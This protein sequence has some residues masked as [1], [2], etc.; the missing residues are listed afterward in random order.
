MTRE[1]SNIIM[2]MSILASSLF[3]IVLGHS[4]SDRRTLK[5]TWVI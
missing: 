2:T 4:P 1:S 3:A 5:K